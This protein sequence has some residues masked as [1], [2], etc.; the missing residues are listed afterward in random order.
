MA[1][2]TIKTNLT[3]VTDNASTTT[4]A[5]LDGVPFTTSTIISS[6]TFTVNSNCT[7]TTEPHVDL[8][9]TSIPTDYSITITEVAGTSKTFTI[10]YR[11]PLKPPTTDVIIFSAIAK[12]DFKTTGSKIYQYQINE[13]EIHSNGEN[14]ILTVYGDAKTSFSLDVTKN[15]RINPIGDATVIVGPLAYYIIGDDGKYETNIKFPKTTLL[16]D[17]R[18]KLSERISGSFTG[19]PNPTT[20]TLTQYPLQQTKLEIIETSDTTWVLPAASVTNAF[21][22]YSAKKGQTTYNNYFSFTCTHTGDISL[23][24]TFTS[25]DFTQVTGQSSTL[26]DTAIDSEVEYS[27]LSIT[28]N[29]DVS[30]N[31]VRIE[32]YLKIKHG[33]DSGGHTYITLNINDILN[34]A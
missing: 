8:S 14:R 20:T 29:N 33:Y 16:T 9:N 34:H 22:Y 1:N 4:S 18:I 12:V 2:V 28:I 31:T 17:Y 24:G 11:H 21:Y 13:R 30:P 19:I 26:T 25:A 10:K 3:N 32:G 23:D 15:P 6:R 27:D 7:F 5:S